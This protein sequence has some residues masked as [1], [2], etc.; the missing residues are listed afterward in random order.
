MLANA[1]LKP[2]GIREFQFRKR[3]KFTMRKQK[4]KKLL[5]ELDVCTKRLDAYFDKSERLQEPYKAEKRSKFKV[6]LQSIENNAAR[7]YD[8]L[9]RTWCSTH[10]SHQAGLL[11]EQRLV[12]RQKRTTNQQKKDTEECDIDCLGISLLQSPSPMK[13]LEG[14]IRLIETPSNYHQYRF[15]H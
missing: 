8:V 1:P 2:H 4:V 13:W 3:V 15:V 6:F 5:M 11:L 7:L 9:S 14:E 12:K 10:P